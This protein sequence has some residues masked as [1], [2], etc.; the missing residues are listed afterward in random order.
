MHARIADL[1]Q[2]LARDA[3]ALARAVATLD[4]LRRHEADLHAEFTAA[5]A[6]A[7]TAIEML[8]GRLAAARTL[9]ARMADELAARDVAAATSRQELSALHHELAEARDRLRAVT[10]STVW[11]ASSPLRV[12]GRH[13]PAGL[14]TALRR[15]IRAPQ[16]IAH[17]AAPKNPES[18]PVGGY[19]APA[20]SDPPTLAK[21]SRPRALIIDSRWPRP[22][23]DSGSLD[24]MMQI[25]ALER[26]GYEI[27]FASEDE[28]NADSP[29][30]TRLQAEAVICLSPEDSPS[31]EDFLRTDGES[32][33]LCILSRVYCGGRYVEVARR[34][35]PQAKI[36][37]N[38]VD[39]HHL[40]MEREGRLLGDEDL[41]RRAADT[42]ARE[43]A[44]ARQADATIVVSSVERVHLERA[45]PGAR[46]FDMPLA[47]KIRPA[48][49]IPGFAA[50]FGIGFV[51][52]FEH[53]PN[54]DAVRFLL[55]EIWPLVLERLPQARLSIVG[56]A[57]PPTMLDHAPDSVRYLGHLPELDPW[58]DTIRLTVA[59]LR[60][61]AGAKGK[62]ISSLAAGLPC[63]ST[64][65]GAEGMPLDAGLHITVA[66]TAEA[67][68]QRIVEVHE[69]ADLWKRLSEA[70]HDRVRRNFSLE[71][72]QARFSHLLHSLHLPAGPPAADC[73][74][75]VMHDQDLTASDLERIEA[76]A[77]F[78][79]KTLASLNERQARPDDVILRRFQADIVTRGCFDVP[80]P[81]TGLILSSGDAVILPDRTVFY[82]FPNEPR[83][84]LAAA[85][86][87]RGYPIVGLVLL[88]SR[89]LIQLDERLWGVESRDVVA[90]LAFLDDN[91]WPPARPADRCLILTGDSNFAHHAWNQLGALAALIDGHTER[92]PRTLCTTFTPLGAIDALLPELSHWSIDHLSA[93][94]PPHV[95]S[96]GRVIVNLGGL[97]VTDAI[98]D[99][100]LRV[101]RDQESEAVRAIRRS[102]AANTPV[103]WVSVRTRNRTADN[104]RDFIVAACREIV[105]SYPDAAIILDGHSVPMDAAINANYNRRDIDTMITGD[106]GEIEAVIAALRSGSDPS[107]AY[108]LI[109]ASGLTILESILLAHAADFY[110]CHH[111]TVQHKI[112]WMTDRPGVVHSNP[113]TL[114][115]DPAPWVA[116]QAGHERAPVYFPP[117][118]IGDAPVAED[119][120]DPQTKS[121]LFENYVFLDVAASVEFCMEQLRLVL[122]A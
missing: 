64:A 54:V 19:E 80:S 44:I 49:R 111:G 6:R 65:I 106:S 112:G 31:I 94:I 12:L 117:A 52:G 101:A 98:R 81:F 22:D 5:Q 35:A 75:T 105:S 74:F 57:L 1:E 10:T 77:P 110:I 47:R 67:F 7:I 119:T 18:Q 93:N 28:Y 76:K 79:R 21:P 85:N 2:R 43:F 115:I 122:D 99:R 46:I 97:R 120:G 33:D 121:R 48:S 37:F 42:R 87:A 92:L 88:N 56:N 102:L 17:A 34:Y 71:A 55:G 109:N 32:L 72:G 45:V 62:V 4:D 20:L 100:V 66:D 84:L 114:S 103:V 24:A 9:H 108:S 23:Q 51:G 69:D 13:I 29:Y 39:L 38:T 40:R 8:N 3:E 41:L 95:N 59:P 104:Q 26:F 91:A 118:L 11:R 53:T 68:A 60:Y 89:T 82:R 25:R 96:P 15:A 116:L 36:L 50:R 90:A 30:R 16:R 61:G 83:L 27:L 14:R 73:P 70:G 78:I 63:I 113:R 107:G 58:L 86:L